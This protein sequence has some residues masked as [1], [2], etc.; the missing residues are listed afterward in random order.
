VWACAGLGGVVTGS[1]SP[2]RSGVKEAVVAALRAGLGVNEMVGLL[3]YELLV[4]LEAEG[5]AGEGV[6]SDGV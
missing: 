6:G 2:N 3:G 4:Y 5:S 1:W